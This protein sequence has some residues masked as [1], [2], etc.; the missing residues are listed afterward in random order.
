MKVKLSIVLMALCLLTTQGFAD[1]ITLNPSYDTWLDKS[2]PDTSYGSSST[3]E[4]AGATNR[5]ALFQFDL[6][7]IPSGATINSAHIDAFLEAQNGDSYY[8]AYQVISAWDENATFNN[9]T[10]GTPWNN[11]GGDFNGSPAYG[12]GQFFDADTNAYYT[13][14]GSNF[15]DLVQDWVDGT[16]NN[17]GIIVQRKYGSTAQNATFT[18]S[19]AGSNA[20]RLVVDY[21]AIPEPASLVFFGMGLLIYIWKRRR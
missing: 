1:I 8:Y 18:S 20:P 10:S 21:T 13:L 16:E 2:N 17:Y 15:K 5:Q 6:S 9:R 4:W 14:T 19:E 11:P 7:S 12:N 3:L